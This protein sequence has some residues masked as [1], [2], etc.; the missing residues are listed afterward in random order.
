MIETFVSFVI[1]VVNDIG[2]SNS[3]YTQESLKTLIRNIRLPATA[4]FQSINDY[5]S[6]LQSFSFIASSITVLL[7]YGLAS[8]PLIHNRSRQISGYFVTLQNRVLNVTLYTDA[9]PA[10]TGFAVS[11]RQNLIPT[12]LRTYGAPFQANTIVSIVCLRTVAADNV[13]GD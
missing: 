10:V 4:F 12:D 6:Q 1:F 9:I 11:E 3:G 8:R 2:L 13:F 7:T 5:G